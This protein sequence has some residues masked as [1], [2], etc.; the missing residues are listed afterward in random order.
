[1][2]LRIGNHNTNSKMNSS[3]NQ[4]KIEEE[5]NNER[6]DNISIQQLGGIRNLNDMRKKYLSKLTYHKVWLPPMK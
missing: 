5:S 2:N 4:S 3:L 6:E 1:M